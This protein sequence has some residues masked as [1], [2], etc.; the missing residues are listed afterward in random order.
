MHV[1]DMQGRG[2]NVMCWHVY[3]CSVHLYRGWAIFI[4]LYMPFI[5]IH[6]LVVHGILCNNLVCGH[7]HALQSS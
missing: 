1:L 5:E 7:V 3:K 6:G 2:K 4:Y